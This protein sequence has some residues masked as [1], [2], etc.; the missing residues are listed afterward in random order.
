MEGNNKIV[1]VKWQT[2]RVE[3]KMFQIYR[4]IKN[5]LISINL[6]SFNY[7]DLNKTFDK[8]KND[9]IQFNNYVIKTVLGNNSTFS[10]GATIAATRRAGG[11]FVIPPDLIEYINQ[12]ISST[13]IFEKYISGFPNT[14]E[15]Y[16]KGRDLYQ[17]F[18]DE[19]YPTQAA[20]ALCGAAFVECAWNPNVY[21]KEEQ[22]KE[23][24]TVA[25]AGGWS[26]CG[27]GLFGLTGWGQ[28]QAII[29]KLGLN[30]NGAQ[31]YKYN[32]F[33]NLNKNET[34]T[35]KI[36]AD[37][38]TYNQGPRKH[39]LL[40]QCVESVW[41]KI[42]KEYLSGLPKHG[43]DDKKPYDYLMYAG[44]PVGSSES[45]DDDHRL[46]YASYLFKAG[47]GNGG[48]TFE[49]MVKRVNAYKRTHK[50]IYSKKNPDYTPIDGF[51]KQLLI[52]Y[53]LAEY[54]NDTPIEEL[55]LSEICTH[56]TESVRGRNNGHSRGGLFGQTYTE[57]NLSIDD[58][59]YKQSNK[60]YDI[61]IACEWITKHS[62]SIS[63]HCC[64]KYVRMAIEAGFRDK[65]ATVGRP[66]WAWKYINYLPTIGFKFL[67]KVTRSTMKNYIPKKG[68][69]AVYLKGGDKN[70]PGHICMYTG[71]RWIS[72]FKQNNMIV[73]K[74]TNEA[75][76][77]RFPDNEDEI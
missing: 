27:E 20:Y 31:C 4:D 53:L 24:G 56:N 36:P 1:S 28:K 32:I 19:G 33:G 63:L 25:L 64:A 59:L 7:I 57:D 13:L 60:K 46:L 17:F 72:D 34:V 23:G 42:L 74:T 68:D 69:I 30:V 47:Y 41:V 29:K 44:T 65:N 18:I 8:E 58:A 48:T 21:N 55:S 3:D 43:D 14:T 39:A 2:E 37:E 73:Y 52:A 12:E 26:G 67:Q 45:N 62:K 35:R 5:D 71:E 50:N 38:Y 77:Y 9:K 76:I 49:N 16:D 40:F 22:K 70:V 66:N 15:L 54:V 75:Y 51:I 10:V 61:D 6:S 11:H